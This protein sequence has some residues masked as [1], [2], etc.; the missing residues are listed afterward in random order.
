MI[1]NILS[2]CQTTWSFQK[3]EKKLQIGKEGYA[4][5]LWFYT[6]SEG[7]TEARDSLLNPASFLEIRKDGTYTRD[8]GFFEY[9]SWKLEDHK[10][11]LTNQRH[12]TVAFP[13][14]MSKQ[15]ELRLTVDN[16]FK[17]DFESQA[18]PDAGDKDPFSLE[19]N[20]WRIPATHKESAADIR[21][22][23]YNHCQFWEKYF[24]WALDNVISTIDV[25]SMP[26]CLKIYGKGFTLKSFDDLPAMW[27][28]YFFDVEDCQKANDMIADIF[29]NRNIAWAHTENKYKLFIGAFQQMESFL[30]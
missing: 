11:Y 25:R 9:G 10:L 8:F 29:R 12:H 28:F 16:R 7:P 22:R 27:K 13:V 14:D 5:H 1:V 4:D 23:L 19:N 20:Q 30:R 3:W 17:A 21:K 6:Y 15:G 2:P 26:T 18:L 24:G